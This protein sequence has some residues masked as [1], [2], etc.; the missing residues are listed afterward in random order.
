MV[1]ARNSGRE[2]LLL[3]RDEEQLEDAGGAAADLC[4]LP[5]PPLRIGIHHPPLVLDLSRLLERAGR[6]GLARV[7]AD[8]R[9]LLLVTS[10]RIAHAAPRED[11]RQLGL[12][13]A[14]DRG[15]AGGRHR[16]FEVVEL[17][18]RPEFVSAG[19]DPLRCEVDLDRSGQARRIDTGAPLID[20]CVP[21]PLGVDLRLDRDDPLLCSVGL[22]ALTMRCRVV[23]HGAGRAEWQLQPL[24]SAQ[25]R[26]QPLV[27]ILRAPRTSRELGL[28]MGLTCEFDGGRGRTRRYRAPE[29]R[30]N[31]A[32]DPV[33]SGRS[34]LR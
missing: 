7:S 31:V 3:L 2:R 26:R 5:V 10:L 34:G 14:P 18:P 27:A 17:L 11:L 22:D 23:H 24:P 28:R 32:I 30:G 33:P 29:L 13:I 20:L 15:T 16:G 19:G 1:V 21:L 9:L 8:H 25:L 4:A 12:R 6:D